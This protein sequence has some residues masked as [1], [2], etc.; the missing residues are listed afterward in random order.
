YH[1][2]PNNP[3]YGQQAIMGM[4]VHGIQVDVEPDDWGIW[5]YKEYPA[6]MIKG[7]IPTR[8]TPLK[9]S[10]KLVSGFHWTPRSE[11]KG[12]EFRWTDGDLVLLLKNGRCFKYTGIPNGLFWQLYEATDCDKFIGENILDKFSEE[13]LEL[14]KPMNK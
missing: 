14:P 8:L 6:E 2:Y 11:G 12:N 1:P 4:W 5:F 9:D 10:S 3:G 7:P 13:E